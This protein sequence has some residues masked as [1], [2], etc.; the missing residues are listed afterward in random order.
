MIAVLMLSN[1]SQYIL[2]KIGIPLFE[3]NS[4]LPT[5][6]ESTLHFYQK[7]NILTLHLI[8]VDAYPEKEINLL[9][10]IIDSIRGD[11]A[12]ATHGTLS[13]FSGEPIKLE[14][15]LVSSQPAKTVLVFFDAKLLSADIQFIESPPLSDM[16]INPLLKK[17]LWTQIKPLTVN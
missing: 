3:D 4:Q 8:S 11:Y 15:I 1:K 6:E 17:N 14:Q 12:D 5:K 9:N 7:D 13:Y 16:A 2:S 10:A